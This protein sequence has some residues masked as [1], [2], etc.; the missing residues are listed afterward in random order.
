M[1]EV[2]V[3]EQLERHV[4]KLKYAVEMRDM[5]VRLADNRDFRKL[6]LDGFCVSEAA[7]YV[8]ESG[9][10]ALTP[11]QRADALNLAQASGHLKRFIAI[12]IQLGN[13]AAEDVRS[14]EEQIDEVRRGG[15]DE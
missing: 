1:S 10:P 14:T 5:A 8:Q 7:R 11:N 2:N 12:T 3:L 9:D 15:E 13:Q 4:E 6:I